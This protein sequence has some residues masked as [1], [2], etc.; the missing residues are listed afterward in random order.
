MPVCPCFIQAAAKGKGKK[1]V[2]AMLSDDEDTAGEDSASEGEWAPK[3]RALATFAATSPQISVAV[4][5][6]ARS[7][8]RAPHSK[9]KKA[10]KFCWHP[11]QFKFLR[12]Y[13]GMLV[14]QKGLYILRVS[15]RQRSEALQ[16]LLAAFSPRFSVAI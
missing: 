6:H 9:G 11:L 10:P 1:K 2:A 7:P 13:Y 3:V 15:G 5:W 4:P 16:C 8:K 14:F 12:R